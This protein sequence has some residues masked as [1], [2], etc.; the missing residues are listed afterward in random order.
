MNNRL[1]KIKINSKKKKYVKLSQQ[2]GCDY[3]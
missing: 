1:L 3:L 2:I